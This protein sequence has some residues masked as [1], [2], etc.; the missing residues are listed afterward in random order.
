MKEGRSVTP[1]LFCRRPETAQVLSLRGCNGL[2]ATITLS[3][4]DLLE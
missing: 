2:C 4:I 1:V 3:L